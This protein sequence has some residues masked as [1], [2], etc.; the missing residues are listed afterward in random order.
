MATLTIK[1]DSEDLAREV[2]THLGYLPEDDM[3]DLVTDVEEEPVED[4]T[5]IDALK[6]WSKHRDCS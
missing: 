3:P 1:I 2:L 4:S 6:E 5:T